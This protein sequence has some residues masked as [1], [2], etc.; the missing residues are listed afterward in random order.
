MLMGKETHRLIKRFLWGLKP[1]SPLCMIRCGGIPLLSELWCKLMHVQ[2]WM[3][4]IRL[5][6][7]ACLISSAQDTALR[8]D[9]LR[10]S[11]DV[12]SHGLFPL[13]LSAAATSMVCLGC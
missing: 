6:G 12:L 9:E 11:V 10:S 3:C 1:M 2:H 7:S 13:R 5:L 4:C 8:G